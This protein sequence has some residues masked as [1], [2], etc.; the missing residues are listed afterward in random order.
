MVGYM[1]T[2]PLPLQDRDVIYSD[3]RLKRNIATAGKQQRKRDEKH[4][5]TPSTK[6]KKES[7]G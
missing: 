1:K 7:T 2:L 3:P 6:G 4:V 5:F